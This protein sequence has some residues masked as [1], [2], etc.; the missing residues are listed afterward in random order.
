MNCSKVL[1]WVSIRRGAGTWL[2]VLTLQVIYPPSP[3]S[4]GGLQF[5]CLRRERVKVCESLHHP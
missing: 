3:P 2:L 4:L 5:G 1:E